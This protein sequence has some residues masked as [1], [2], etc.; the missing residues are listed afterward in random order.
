[1]TTLSGIRNKLFGSILYQLQGAF[2]QSLLLSLLA[3]FGSVTGT[4]LSLSLISRILSLKQFGVFSFILSVQMILT[5]AIELGVTPTVIR[6]SSHYIGSDQVDR[7]YSI[8]KL[9]LVLK[10]VLNALLL[11]LGLVFARTIAIAVYHNSSL[12]ELLVGGFVL[13]SCASFQ[14]YFI[15]VLRSRNRFDLVAVA[16]VVQYV[17]QLA[18][19]L[20]FWRLGQTTVTLIVISY[21][22]GFLLFIFFCAIHYPW[23]AVML[24][25][26]A[27]ESSQ[28]KVYWAFLKWMALGY[29]T[30]ALMLHINVPILAYSQPPEEVARYFSAFKIAQAFWIM[31][32]VVSFVLLPRLSQSVGQRGIEGVR[33]VVGKL[34]VGSAF[35]SLL[36]TVFIGGLAGPLVAIVFGKSYSSSVPVLYLLLPA[37]VCFLF[38][39]SGGV[40][41]L[42]LGRS[43][44]G[45]KL[46]LLGVVLNI[47]ANVML[48][49]SWGA[50]GTAVSVQVTFLVQAVAIWLMIWHLLRN[51]NRED[52]A[53]RVL[54]PE[55]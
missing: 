44:I 28:F 13:A 17:T 7:S 51:T 37:G 32:S 33:R 19:L 54:E 49:P 1:M 8:Y 43:D 39:N 35:L 4:Y 38:H 27:A 18:L 6:Y 34:L 16:F 30:G 5:T 2:F 41:L 50:V 47:I 53:A 9:G 14:N 24:N 46:G 12:T 21:V 15:G 11:T 36:L 25:S 3:R 42:S 23:K 10:I 29:I 22:A 40:V 45:A 48:V 31:E 55:V 26:L 20:L 52:P